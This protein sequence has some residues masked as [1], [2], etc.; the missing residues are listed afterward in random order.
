MCPARGELARTVADHANVR[1]CQ[2]GTRARFFRP[3][4]AT[5]CGL[6]GGRF[7]TANPARSK[8]STSRFAM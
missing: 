6:M 7:I 5:E 8:W 3:T 4:Q 2:D 1:L